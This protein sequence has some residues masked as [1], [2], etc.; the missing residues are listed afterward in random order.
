MCVQLSSVQVIK[1]EILDNPAFHQVS[2]GKGL[3]ADCNTEYRISLSLFRILIFCCQYFS[4]TLN[5][6]LGILVCC[7]SLHM[8]HRLTTVLLVSSIWTV[9]VSVTLQSLWEAVTHVP[10]WKLAKRASILYFHP[11]GQQ[12]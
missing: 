6:L 12:R 2:D 8:G 10:A 9:F 11:A 5:I 3:S 4:V 1:C 7:C